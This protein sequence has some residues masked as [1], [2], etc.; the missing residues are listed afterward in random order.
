MNIMCE[1]C[2]ALGY[3]EPIDYMPQ[4]LS[5]MAMNAICVGRHDIADKLNEVYRYINE[6][7]E[8][9]NQ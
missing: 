7:P 8:A 9:D 1:T 5:R 4:E 2:K 3:E 6:H